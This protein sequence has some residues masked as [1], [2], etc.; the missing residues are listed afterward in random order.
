MYSWGLAGASF[1]VQGLLQPDYSCVRQDVSTGPQDFWRVQAR[2]LSSSVYMQTGL[3]GL[4]KA[5]L[6][7]SMASSAM[8][9]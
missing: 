9:P 4:L 3:A 5:N 6:A 7:S 2:M 8:A 1:A